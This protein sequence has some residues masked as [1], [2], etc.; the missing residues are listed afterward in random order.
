[1][2]HVT[3]HFIYVMSLRAE[4]YQHRIL[5]L[6]LSA[7]DKHEGHE[8]KNEARSPRDSSAAAVHPLSGEYRRL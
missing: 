4:L 8:K 7:S 3:S 5:S 1:M 6:L 2:K